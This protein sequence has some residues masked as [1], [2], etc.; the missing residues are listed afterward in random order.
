[1]TIDRPEYARSVLHD[2]LEQGEGM[3]VEFKANNCNHDRIG[4]YISG[5]ANGACYAG[6]HHAYLVW[7]VD[8]KTR[9]IVG[10]LFDPNHEKEGNEGL[11]MW[12][13]KM[14]SPDIAFEFYVLYEEGKKIVILQV[15]PAYRK[16]VCFKNK[17]YIRD[18]EH[19]TDLSRYPNV[20]QKI[21]RTVGKDWSA[22][23]VHDSTC[24]DLDKTAL[25]FARKQ[26]QEKHKD[27]AFADEIPGWDDITFLNK[28]KLAIKGK[29]TKAAIVLLG[30]PES[31][32]FLEEA[33][34]RITWL[35]KDADNTDVDYKHFAP[36]FIL[37][38]DEI[39]EKKIRNIKIR[40]MPDGTLFPVEI[41]QYDRWVFR[42][43]LHNCI[44]HQ[45]YL[46]RQSI[47]VAEHPDYVRFSNAGA[48][49]P[50][51]V[52]NVLRDN[53]RPREYLNKQLVEAM[54]ELKMIDTIGSGIRR[55]F[56]TQKKHFMPLPDYEIGNDRVVVKIQGKILDERYTKLLM[57]DPNLSLENI[58]LL[59]RLQK[60][61][62]IT[63]EEAARLRKNK[64]IE[65]RYPHVYPA[66][67]ISRMT[68]KLEDYAEDKELSDSLYCQK[69]LEYI[70]RKGHASRRE[71]ASILMK[72]FSSR[73][74]DVQKENKISNLLSVTL[75]KRR[76]WI[77][78]EGPKHKSVWKLTE[79]G[80]IAC[81]K[82]NSE[83][84]K[85]CGRIS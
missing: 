56:V 51:S 19:L 64:L 30:K 61:V 66:E 84:K 8:D 62:G 52:E 21:Y 75:S 44:A 46:L 1:M 50:G 67:S 42:E 34:L 39:F 83:C 63:K 33:F 45:D 77:Y 49:W 27:D 40:A 37:A 57:K 71:I 36:P 80:R 5:L 11:S 16:P 25:D 35:L 18:H 32:H 3:C 72:H 55:M 22:E 28:A 9:K 38:V 20:Q 82:G 69:I 73:K 23:I 54:V 48:F 13:K 43:A 81:K 76:G 14:L 29:L 31:A 10:T 79:E 68:N 59:D 12:L 53:E 70:C 24:D 4:M 60:G 47:V 74:T 15:E 7:G 2:L 58:I 6:W 78:N 41:Q 65:G 85:A 26:F 17:A